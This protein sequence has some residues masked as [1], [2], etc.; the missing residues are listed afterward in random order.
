M[1]YIPYCIQPLLLTLLAN[2]TCRCLTSLH[3]S[4]LLVVWSYIAYLC[5]WSYVAYRIYLCTVYIHCLFVLCLRSTTDLCMLRRAA[6]CPFDFCQSSYFLWQLTNGASCYVDPVDRGTVTDTVPPPH[7][8]SRSPHEPPSSLQ[9]QLPNDD[10]A[11]P[12]P[13]LGTP[14][15]APEKK[16]KT[17]LTPVIIA[18][19]A[20]AGTSM[21]C[22]FFVFAGVVYRKRKH[23]KKEKEEEEL[24]V[25]YSWFSHLML[26]QPE[27]V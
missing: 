12:P 18:V 15:K 10:A 2:S 8:P 5:A 3:I 1:S 7:A 27:P 19:C 17:W 16:K 9:T 6:G 21:F 23:E 14:T 20:A 24:V 11:A 26:V 4:A 25:R 22:A 13:L